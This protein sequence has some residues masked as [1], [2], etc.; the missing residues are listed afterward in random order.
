MGATYQSPL[1]T[2]FGDG[3]Y[4]VGGHIAAGT[5]RASTGAGCY[6]ERLSGFGGRF[7]EIVAN[8]YEG[9]TVVTIGSG[10]RGFRTDGCGTWQKQ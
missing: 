2:T 3:T 7:E 6:W 10:D 1:A 5:Y 9:S 4:A 8:D